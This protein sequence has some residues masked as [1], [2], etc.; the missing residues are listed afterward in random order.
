MYIRYCPALV[1]GDNCGLFLSIS[2]FGAET[3]AIPLEILHNRRLMENW[4]LRSW[5]QMNE[6]WA[7]APLRFIKSIESAWHTVAIVVVTGRAR[8]WC[9]HELL[10]KREQAGALGAPSGSTDCRYLRCDSCQVPH[11]G[12]CFLSFHIFQPFPYQ[13]VI[14]QT[15]VLV[16]HP[17]FPLLF[18][19]R[20]SLVLSYPS[21]KCAAK[22]IG[23]GI[24]VSF[25]P[26]CTRTHH[27]QLC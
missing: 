15:F 2:F 26:Y 21:Q 7:A 17:L 16:N 6:A 13:R 22:Y 10:D 4:F 3:P 11:S 8:W 14:N 5:S 25:D 24:W 12:L 1:Q 18:F 9:H 27:H 19:L 20:P 23:I